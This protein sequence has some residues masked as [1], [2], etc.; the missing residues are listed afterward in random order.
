MNTAFC[1]KKILAKKSKFIYV[2]Q[3][4]KEMFAEILLFKLTGKRMIQED[5]IL[6]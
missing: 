5:D 4:Q 3:I 2:K 1:N 6:P